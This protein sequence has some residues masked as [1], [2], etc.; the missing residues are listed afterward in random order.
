MKNS[1]LLEPKYLATCYR[2]ISLLFLLLCHCD[3]MGPTASVDAQ[4]GQWK[5]NLFILSGGC[6]SFNCLQ[7]K[8]PHSKLWL[9]TRWWPISWLANQWSAR[10]TTPKTSHS[11]TRNVTL[12]K[13]S[14]GDVLVKWSKLH[15]VTS[16][17]IIIKNSLYTVGKC[18]PLV[19]GQMA[20]GSIPN[21]VSECLTPLLP[22]PVTFPGWNIHTYMPANSILMTL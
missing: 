3:Q 17:Y 7:V 8:M 11:L 5:F 12:M 19:Y 9:M 21:K 16:Y 4:N 6:F 10:A 1:G 22:Q 18:N 14:L 20:L 15:Q 13:Q 2:S